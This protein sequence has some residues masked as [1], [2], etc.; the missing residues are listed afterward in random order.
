MKAKKVLGLLEDYG[1]TED[2]IKN[3]KN[4]DEAST[5]FVGAIDALVNHVAASAS[6]T[7][8]IIVKRIQEIMKVFKEKYPF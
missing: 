6:Y 8:D 7:P 2:L 4:R 1:S 3:S 5:Y